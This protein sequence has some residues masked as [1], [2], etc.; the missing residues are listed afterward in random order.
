MCQELCHAGRWRHSGSHWLCLKTAPFRLAETQVARKPLR[1]EFARAALDPGIIRASGMWSYLASRCIES[2]LDRRW[3]E[4][5][6]CGPD[7]VVWLITWL[8]DQIT[9]FHDHGPSSGRSRSRQASSR[10]SAPTVTSRRFTSA[11]FARSGHRM[12]TTCATGRRAGYQHSCL[13]AAAHRDDPLRAPGRRARTR[14]G[15][16]RV[17]G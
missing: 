10:R 14:R 6:H 9:G 1:L 8:P 12:R 7:Y 4:R 17:S 16:L 3:Y 13:L 5:L 15:I 11:T 2:Y